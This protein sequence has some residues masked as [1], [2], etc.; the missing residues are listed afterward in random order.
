MEFDC[1]WTWTITASKGAGLEK[2]GRKSSLI[3]WGS[4]GPVLCWGISVHLEQILG[5]RSTLTVFLF[6]FLSGQGT[7]ITFLSSSHR[8]H[9]SLLR[10]LLILLSP[11]PATYRVQRQHVHSNGYNGSSGSLLISARFSK[12][13]AVTRR[14]FAGRVWAGGWCGWL[15][16]SCE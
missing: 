8:C 1:C 16:V 12:T 13:L 14:P 2:V 11:A 15:R 3:C 5:F 9:I 6:I 4:L 10:P 7:Q